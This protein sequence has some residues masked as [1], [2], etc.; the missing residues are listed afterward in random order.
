LQGNTAAPAEKKSWMPFPK[1]NT[2]MGGRQVGK[3]VGIILL[4]IQG[5]PVGQRQRQ[6]GG[7]KVR[8]VVSSGHI[9]SIGTKNILNQEPMLKGIGLGVLQFNS[10][11]GREKREGKDVIHRSSILK[12]A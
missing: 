1:A 9:I 12:L 6:G 2:S 10:K 4:P 8:R 3:K 11:S 7:G 5:E